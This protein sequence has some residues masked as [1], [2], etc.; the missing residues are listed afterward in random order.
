[1]T[2]TAYILLVAFAAVIVAEADDTAKIG[3]LEIG[4]FQVPEAHQA[5]AVDATSIF[6]ISNRT[7]ARYAKQPAGDD[8]EPLAKWT[9]EAGSPIIH[10]N[11][12]FVCDDR[13]Y[14]AN[15]NWPAKPLEN[16]VEVYSADSLRHLE[17][18]A[19]SESSGAINW[20][21]RHHGAWWI[22]F[23]FYGEA[24]VRKTR[25]V[26]YDDQ[27]NETGTWSFPESVITRF[28]PNSNSGG[29]FAPNGQLFVTG[30]DHGELY[31]LEVP[32]RGEKL[33]HV[34]TIDAPIAG[35]GIAWDHSHPGTLFGIVRSKHEVVSMQVSK[36]VPQV[37]VIKDVPY[38]GDGRTE[39]LDLYLPANDGN[40]KRPAIV[41]VHGGGW[42]GGDKAAA[43]E[44]NIGNEL[45]RVGY[46]CASINYRLSENNEN[47]A[48]RLRQ[49]W[50]GNLHDCKTA[51]RFLRMKADEYSIDA[52]NIGAIGGS[53][54]GH[55]VAMMAVTDTGDGLDPAEPYGEY[56]CRIQA[57]V[58]MYGVHDL[59]VHAEMKGHALN[60]DDM[61]LCRQ[62]SPATWVTSD[63]PP[64][65]ILHGTKDALVPVEQSNILQNRLE[66]ANVVSQLIV[67]D[68]APHSFHLQPKQRDLRPDVISFFDRHLRHP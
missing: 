3:V 24:D 58:P 62:A 59:S 67:I 41:I 51:V 61:A 63:D 12:G 53:A 30:H 31:V 32:G 33:V 46:V 40:Q 19:F 37:N 66:S 23:A 20:I 8:K 44:Q 5:V 22:V 57:V 28:L 29:G 27:W 60:E 39:K 65:L 68:G 54:G 64:A 26:R 55:L 6:A 9:A 56:S 2:R 15:S 25:L 7:I 4:R 49:V 47:L 42:H 1:M 48:S 35:Q 11:S 16:S 38:L 21:D 52:N 50:P 43:R 18:I 13:L 10:L 14:C 36:V 34:A 17:S 45:A